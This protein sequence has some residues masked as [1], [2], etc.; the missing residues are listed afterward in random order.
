MIVQYH[1]ATSGSRRPIPRFSLRVSKSSFLCSVIKVIIYAVVYWYGHLHRFSLRVGCKRDPYELDVA[2]NVLI[3]LGCK[4]AKSKQIRAV[5]ETA[6]FFTRIYV[7]GTLNQSREHF[8]EWLLW[9]RVEG[10]LIRVKICRFKNIR[11]TSSCIH[12]LH[13]TSHQVSRRSRAV[14]DKKI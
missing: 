9:F 4:R 3:Q 2:G 5:F 8:R 1:A 7:E 10:R 11:V 14:D 13:K 6:H 12:A